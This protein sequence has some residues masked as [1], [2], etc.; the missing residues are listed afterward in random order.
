MV[1]NKESGNMTVIGILSHGV[2]E[3]DS[4][5]PAIFTRVGKYLDWIN[6]FITKADG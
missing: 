1:Q 2:R 4:S 3:C 5:K 6:D